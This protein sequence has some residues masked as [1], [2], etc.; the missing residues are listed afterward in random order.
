MAPAL[1]SLPPN[2]TQ[3][4]NKWKYKVLTTNILLWLE[5]HLWGDQSPQYVYI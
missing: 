2:E 1:K 3:E 4:M 5:V